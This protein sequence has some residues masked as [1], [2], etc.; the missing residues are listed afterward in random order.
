MTY[1]ALHFN[2]V[3]GFYNCLSYY[4]KILNKII[5]CEENTKNIKVIMSSRLTFVKCKQIRWYSTKQKMKVIDEVDELLLTNQLKHR[6]HPGISSPRQVQHPSWLCDS[7]KALAGVNNISLKQVQQGTKRL[8]SYLHERQL[9]KEADDIETKIKDIKSHTKAININGMEEPIDHK[10]LLKNPQVLKQLKGFIYS[11][12]SINYDA[13]TSLVY[14]FGRSIPEYSVLYKIF[15]EIYTDD[16][17][18]TPKSLFDYGSG[19]GTVMWAASE[20]W[21]K[22]IKE[23]YCVDVSRFMNEFSEYLMKMAKPKINPHHVF[24]RQFFPAAPIPTYDIV[25]SAYSLLELPDQKSRLEVISKLWNKTNH[26]L[27]IVEQGTAYGF[28][29]ITE[30]RDFILRHGRKDTR[31]VHVFSPC[32]HDL[33]CPIQIADYKFPCSFKIQ[34]QT[35]PLAQKSEYKMELYS[36]VVLKKGKRSENDNQWPRIISPILKR[37]KHVVC[38]MCTASGK[39]EEQIFTA[40]KNGK[41][42]YRCARSSAWGDRLPFKF[43]EIKES[44]ESEDSDQFEDSSESEESEKTK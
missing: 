16:E 25:V 6:H 8:T 23:Y 2:A 19:V 17:N 41:N 27:V 37:S 31:G 11:W 29:V 3:I 42:T 32:P 36:Y 24:Y 21:N 22:S 38:R 33:Q 7:I 14:L 9:P 20:F 10:E 35:L 12:K 30:A 5:L 34:Y 18:F 15:N 40:W 43:E 44:E 1:T 26:Y 4:V 13:F 39:F 28:R